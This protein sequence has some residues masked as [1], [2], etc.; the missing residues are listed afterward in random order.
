M[1]YNMWDIFCEFARLQGM[2][3]VSVGGRYKRVARGSGEFIV[4]CKICEIN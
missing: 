2:H 3:G 1:P 4:L